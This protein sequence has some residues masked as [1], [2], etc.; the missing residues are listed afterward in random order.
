MWEQVRAE[1]GVLQIRPLKESDLDPALVD[2]MTGHAI[3]LL[4]DGKLHRDKDITVAVEELQPNT[5]E[6]VDA[7]IIV[8]SHVA[9]NFGRSNLLAVVRLREWAERNRAPVMVRYAFRSTA[10]WEP[11]MTDRYFVTSVRKSK[12]IYID[13]GR[14]PD[15]TAA[16]VKLALLGEDQDCLLAE[17]TDTSPQSG[18][19]VAQSERIEGEWVRIEGE[20]RTRTE[21]GEAEGILRDA[22]GE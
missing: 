2:R 9:H 6:M 15:G 8:A 13:E 21:G 1:S 20:L 16:L 7:F 10:R 5:T 11:S 14:Y 18:I 19:V 22:K 12:G 4:S 3:Q 17:V